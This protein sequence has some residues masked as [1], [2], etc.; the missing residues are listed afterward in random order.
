W[1]IQADVTAETAEH[2]QIHRRLNPLVFDYL[3]AATGG[4]YAFSGKIAEHHS[5]A[6]YEPFHISGDCVT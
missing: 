5:C 4:S 2:I 6:A 1:V 3:I